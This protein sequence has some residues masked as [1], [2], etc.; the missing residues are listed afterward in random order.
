M[1]ERIVGREWG[2]ADYDHVVAP[3]PVKQ[4]RICFLPEV[5]SGR[6]YQRS[7]Y[8]AALKSLRYLAFFN[9]FI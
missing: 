8:T 3:K 1:L 6:V 4:L 9:H 5:L 7:R 2:R